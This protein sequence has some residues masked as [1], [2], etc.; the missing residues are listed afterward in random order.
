MKKLLKL[1]DTLL[2]TWRDFGMQGVV[3]DTEVKGLR[4]RVGVHRTSFTFFQEHWAKGERRPSTF[5]TLG[6]FP[7]M[8]VA[9]AR[10]AALVIAGR[11][12]SGRIVP[13]RRS[14]A[15]VGPAVA[16]YIEYVKARAA[17]KGKAPIW[18]KNVE[19]LAN[20]HILPAFERWTLAELSA[21]P[22]A[23]AKWHNDITEKS[24]PV[25]ANHAAKVLRAVYRRAAR[26]D[27]SLPPHN[28]ASAVEFNAEQRSQ[29][30]LALVDF[31]KW[32][33]AWDKIESP[34]RK[35]FQ[36][37]NL[38]SGARPG[39]LSKLKWSDVLPRERC[40][41]IRGAK[42]DNDIHVPLSAAIAREFKRARDAARTDKIESP[43][44]FPAR[45]NGHIV[46][47][48]VDGLP[49][50]GMALRRT[51]RTVAADCGVDELLSHFMLGHI[52]AGISR[53]YVAKMVLSSG[54]GMRSA[55]RV[56]SRRIVGL[57]GTSL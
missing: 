43:Y 19:S 31:P 23:V 55:Q 34:I 44:V 29:N 42:A 7:D 45:A 11:N 1:T 24:G 38:L 35:A 37:V 8:S 17:K 22:A 21:L 48:D 13:G 26:L 30:A 2:E 4:V 39:E 25:A 53:G 56:V 32:R 12:A 33:K 18:A 52:P 6:H 40:F 49:A 3:A 46:K 50:H 27:R 14:A 9:D 20:K 57:L 15:K 54:Q 41:V 10:K 51:W 36:N 5:V 47:F 16:G 28:P